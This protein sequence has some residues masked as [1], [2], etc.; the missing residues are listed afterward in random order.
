MKLLQVAGD[1]NPQK[2]QYALFMLNQLVEADAV[3]DW[4]I[5]RGYTG[6]NLEQW[7]DERFD[8]FFLP[9]FDYIRAKANISNP[10]KPVLAG[11]DLC[12]NS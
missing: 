12:S 1:G 10:G 9:M 4:L 2:L 11:R 8:G 7:M 3:C 5:S 6:K